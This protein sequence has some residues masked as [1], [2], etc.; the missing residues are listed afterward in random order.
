[1][2]CPRIFHTYYT[3]TAYRHTVLICKSK[4][5]VHYYC[6]PS[7]KL[8]T[9]LFV[10]VGFCN[11]FYIRCFFSSETPIF[12]YF[13]ICLSHVATVILCLSY[14]NT[15]ALYRCLCF[16]TVELTSYTIGIY[17]IPFY[18]LKILLV[19]REPKNVICFS[20][21]FLQKS[22]KSC[23]LFCVWIKCESIVS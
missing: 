2:Q 10:H 13:E 6:K 3:A 16:E 8:C 7:F 22:K 12:F 14:F 20:D 11:T 19:W 4:K 1:M 18:Q 23:N 9:L 5:A 17:E 15:K 21:A